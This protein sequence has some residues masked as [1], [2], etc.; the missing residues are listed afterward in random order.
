MRGGT[1]PFFVASLA[2]AFSAVLGVARA[3][4]RLVDMVVAEIDLRVVTYSELT[5]EAR[6]AVL[7]QRGPSF[8]QRAVLNLELLRAVLRNILARELLL[9]ESR[10]L[11]LREVSAAEVEEELVKLRG[12]FALHA[13]YIRFLESLGFEVPEG[14]R[15]DEG[16]SP[17]E[18]VSIVRSN[19]QVAR[20][21]ELR[22]RPNVIV[23]DADVRRC[24]QRNEA[25]L[26]GQSLS[27]ARPVIERTLREELQAASL[28]E[29]LGQLEAQANLRY[30]ADFRLVIAES[31]SAA[32]RDPATLRCR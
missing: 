7:E 27:E 30:T 26:L 19:L 8:A 22:V 12:R 1:H 24:F 21:V 29:L 3:E 4:P 9:A 10:R 14:V 15:Q 23:R 16:A 25:R 5:A 28:R 2:L 31:E 11:Q 18:L 6:L 17:P 32:S 20:F 13:D